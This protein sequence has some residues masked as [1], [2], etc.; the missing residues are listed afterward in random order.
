MSEEKHRK[1]I[2]R[3]ENNS[4]AGS[5]DLNDSQVCSSHNI[6][7][8]DGRLLFPFFPPSPKSLKQFGLVKDFC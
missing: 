8:T 3:R 1:G 2:E 6:V 4:A 7:K 5:A